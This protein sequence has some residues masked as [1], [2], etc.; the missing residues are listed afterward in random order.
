MIRYLIIAILIYTAPTWTRQVD[1][2]VS[3]AYDTIQSTRDNAARL[4]AGMP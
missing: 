1:H 3:L 2:L 4:R